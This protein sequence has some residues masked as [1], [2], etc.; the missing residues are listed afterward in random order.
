MSI[1]LMSHIP[2]DSVLWGVIDV[3]QSNSNFCNTK[4]RSQ[5]PWIDGNFFDN[6]FAE[7]LT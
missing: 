5:M 4:T 6:I 3:M 2:D 1:G 7:F